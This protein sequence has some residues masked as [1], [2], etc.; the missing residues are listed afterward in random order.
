QAQE[1][2]AA[3]IDAAG[4]GHRCAMRCDKLPTERWT[5][6]PLSTR[7]RVVVHRQC[8]LDWLPLRVTHIC[9]MVYSCASSYIEDASQ[10]L[11]CAHTAA[12]AAFTNTVA[13]R[14]QGVA[15]ASV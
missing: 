12:Q 9:A 6:L 10:R 8:L 1:S 14:G 13:M 3:I 7:R 15:Y 5:K 2:T 11:R 4:R